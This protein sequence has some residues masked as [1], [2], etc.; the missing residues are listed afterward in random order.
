M[1][2][3]VKYDG[4]EYKYNLIDSHL[5]HP[6]TRVTANGKIWEKKLYNLYKTLL[7]ENDVVIDIG[8]YIGTHT[9]PLSH[10]SKK[11]YAFEGNDDIFSFLNK[12][13]ETNNITNITP[14]NVVLSNSNNLLKFYE[15]NTGTSR[16]SNKLIKGNC[17]VVEPKILDDLIPN[18]E[19]IKLI[20]IDVEG[21]EFEV[22]EGAKNIIEKSRPIIL[23]EV[24]KK[25]LNKL[26]E[27]SEA[28]N[29]IITSLKGEDYL[30]E[31]Q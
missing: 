28:N 21:H 19:K 3:I 27:W 6:P 24:F 1:N 30:L 14:F 18:D 12:N 26:N 20:K 8:A 16:V 29:Y 17:K 23:I 5:L 11:V 13:I 7:N 9:L 15:R 25:N 10:F 22:L 4:F 31:P 2:S